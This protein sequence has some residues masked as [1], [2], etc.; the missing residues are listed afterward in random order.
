MDNE[1]SLLLTS[2][3]S[4]AAAAAAGDEGSPLSFLMDNLV[5]VI[6]TTGCVTVALL[7]TLMAVKKES[8]K[9]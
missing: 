6:V 3:T 9:R 2:S 7:G 8:K 4:T 5:P 1:S